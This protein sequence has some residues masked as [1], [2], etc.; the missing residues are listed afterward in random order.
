MRR[1]SREV[2]RGNL[3]R[4]VQEWALTIK[5]AGTYAPHDAVI[6]Y[7]VFAST[8]EDARRAAGTPYEVDA[9]EIASS[10]AQVFHETIAR[11]GFE[12]LK[13]GER[14][15]SN[16]A[17][18]GFVTDEI[19]R[20]ARAKIPRQKK[21]GW[22]SELAWEVVVKFDEYDLRFDSVRKLLRR[23]GLFSAD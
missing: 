7:K 15:R 14:G 6:E 1:K 5:R 13:G 3:E 19:L 2:R 17:D 21:R 20:Y 10:A 8:T 4:S 16:R 11:T 18:Q 12:V 9:L 22:K 23:H